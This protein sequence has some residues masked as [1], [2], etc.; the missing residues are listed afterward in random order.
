MLPPP[1][2]EHRRRDWMMSTLT[3]YGNEMTGVYE[4]VGWMEERMRRSGRVV[5]SAAGGGGGVLGSGGWGFSDS[6]RVRREEMKRDFAL[7]ALEA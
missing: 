5:E 4:P 1:A 3:H 6:R 2:I 7:F